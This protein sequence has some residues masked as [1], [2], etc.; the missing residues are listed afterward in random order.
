MGIGI[1]VSGSDGMGGRVEIVEDGH[2]QAT[3][4][5]VIDN[6]GAYETGTTG[7]Q[8]MVHHHSRELLTGRFGAA[9]RTWGRLRAETWPG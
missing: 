9:D 8:D 4:H 2:L 7:D 3:R 5:E 1:E 6:M